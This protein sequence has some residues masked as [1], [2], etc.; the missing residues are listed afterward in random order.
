MVN[1]LL[2]LLG[3]GAAYWGLSAPPHREEL[4]TLYRKHSRLFK[5]FG[6]LAL[7][8]LVTSALATAV[9][10]LFCSHAAE[11]VSRIDAVLTAILVGLGIGAVLP[12]F[13]RGWDAARMKAFQARLDELLRT[14]H[15]GVVA[16][17]L[18]KPLRGITSETEFDSLG[19]E[20]LIDRC[21]ESE[22][23]ARVLIIEQPEAAAR[24][25]RIESRRGGSHSDAL[26]R[27]AFPP[28]SGALVRELSRSTN[29]A[30]GD[31]G[32]RIP[33]G[34]IILHALFDDCRVAENLHAWQ[35]IGEAVE[36]ELLERRHA[37]GDDND[38]MPWG[39]DHDDA[40]RSPIFAGIWFFRIMVT[41]SLRQGIEWH[42]WLFYLP[43]FVEAMLANTKVN[44]AE[45]G[46]EFPSR[47]FYCICEAFRV[48]EETIRMTARLDADSPH[49]RPVEGNA[50]NKNESIPKS[51]VLAYVECLQHVLASD[52]VPPGFRQHRV[53]RVAE[54]HA[55]LELNDKPPGLAGALVSALA[56]RGARAC[57]DRL[58]QD[59]RALS[60]LE[61]HKPQF[62]RL[63]ELISAAASDE[64]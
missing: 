33:E 44:E 52:V 56:E 38:N 63:L 2:A 18:A 12:L 48:L 45:L 15:D 23:F 24:L 27:A 37:A 49:R 10:A 22:A 32:Y 62:M 13:D 57:R 64:T 59:L 31:I 58:G 5:V 30:I 9:V 7:G 36:R 46:S 4:R 16:A 11:L 25:L 43:R 1:A 19:L 35:P 34:C 21:F 53:E 26:L 6:A 60:R 20:P 3:L 39:G 51:A 54:L 14:G 42:M 47:Y 29:Y 61:A 55:H 41:S 17:V 8:L 40:W 50:Q 28:V